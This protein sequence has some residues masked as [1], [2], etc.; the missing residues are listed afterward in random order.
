M[1]T[2]RTTDLVLISSWSSG[3]RELF[4]TEVRQLAQLPH[5]ASLKTL[6]V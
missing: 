3:G 1:K 5:A 4:R 2:E 6:V